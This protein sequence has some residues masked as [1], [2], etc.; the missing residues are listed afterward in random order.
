MPGYQQIGNRCGAYATLM[1]LENKGRLG[2]LAPVNTANQWHQSAK[3]LWDAIRF[4]QWENTGFFNAGYSN[5]VRIA[6]ELRT[7]NTEAR[8][9]ASTASQLAAAASSD[10]LKL[11]LSL[12][13]T[14]TRQQG[15]QFVDQDGFTSAQ[16]REAYVIPACIMNPGPN[17]GFHFVLAK[18][19]LAR[20][21][22]EVFDSNSDDL[23]WQDIAALPNTFGQNL[24]THASA[25]LNY[26]LVYTGLSVV[27]EA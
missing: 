6:T 19:K 13:K 3:N 9:Y 27:L 12:V 16:N 11:L 2:A 14:M 26:Q 24:V 21:Q 17:Q 10:D 5:P 7:Y 20:P 25:T 4:A 15:V 1:A 22:M 23:V 18:K 8:I